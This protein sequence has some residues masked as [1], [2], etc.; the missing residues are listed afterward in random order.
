MDQ[1]Q[2][3][4]KPLNGRIILVTG[5]LEGIGRAVALASA[6]AGATVIL[7]SF[8]EKDLTPVY[9]EIVAHGDAEPAILPLDLERAT[10]ADFIAAANIIGE[11]FG[12][13]DGL[14]HCA[15]FAPYLSRIDDYDSDEWARVIKV[16]LTAPFM[17]TQACLPLLRAAKDAS[18]IF[19]SDRVGRTAKAYWGAFAAAKF[20]IEG[21]MQV[22]AEETS[23]NGV[24]RVNSIDPGVVRTTMRATLYP[25][26]DPN[27]NPLP[28]TITPA[29]IALLGP[30]T[31]GQTGHA[32]SVDPQTG[33]LTE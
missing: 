3:D 26:E 19:T 31:R 2:A 1:T 6:A 12:R 13:L 5:A 29:Y 15:A 23:E 18:V 14:V 30:E 25:G 20:G 8:K 33:G 17:L 9:D 16:N 22:L 21:L 4:G 28:E 24:L 11:T 27:T 32:F 10:E 7:S